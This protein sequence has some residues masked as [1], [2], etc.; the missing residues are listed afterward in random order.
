MS[1]ARSTPVALEIGARWTFASALD[2]PGWCRRGRSELA[3]VEALE[4]YRSRYATVIGRQFSSGPLEVVCE[5][6]GTTTTDFGAP[7]V[8]AES[9]RRPLA[10]GEGERL[11][12]IV[13]AAASYFARVVTGAPATLTKGPRGGGR[14]VS[15]I[16][17]H[18]AEAERAY[19]SRLGVRIAPRTPVAEGRAQVLE[20]LRDGCP[21]AAWPARYGARRIAW[22]LLD[23]AWEIEDRSA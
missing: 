13:E 11:S 21:G 3:A 16:A 8:V 10:P 15:G 9:E 23:H 18:V 2:W 6:E 20:A 7:A 14:D 12:T 22:H 1:A 19:A 4:T 17:A 5:L